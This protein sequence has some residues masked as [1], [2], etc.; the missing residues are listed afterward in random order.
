[1]ERNQSFRRTVLMG[2]MVLLSW[3]TVSVGAII[4]G[5]QCTTV[6]SG[7]SWSLYGR[8]EAGDENNILSS[9]RSESLQLHSQLLNP[10]DLRDLGDSI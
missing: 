4:I 8:G 5:V 3:F 7:F 9:L 6:M 2:T 1:M 10:S